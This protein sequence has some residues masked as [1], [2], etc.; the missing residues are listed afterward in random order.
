M[1]EK[2]T[3]TPPRFLKNGHAQTFFPEIFR[4]V[5]G[6]KYSRERIITM[7]NDFIDLDWSCIGSDDLVILCHGMEANSERMYMKGM[8]KIF[9]EN[10]WD[11]LAYNFRGCGGEINR[12]PRFYYSG[13]LDDFDLVISHALNKKNYK[14]VSLIGFSLGGSLVLNYVGIKGTKI[15]PEIKN[16]AALS[17]PCDYVAGSKLSKTNK[18]YVKI[19]VKKLLKKLEAKNGILPDNIQVKDYKFVKDFPGFDSLYTAP[20]HGF[21]S[22]QEYWEKCSCS[23]YISNITIPTLLINA[24]NDPLLCD[25]CFPIEEA[26]LSDK[27]FLE[28]PDGGGHLG[29]V[30]FGTKG[31]YWH[32]E[33]VLSFISENGI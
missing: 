31:K 2:S 15:I 23:Q 17:V 10:G 8:V 19:F 14:R 12:L 11:G 6:V 13:D 33:R 20:L 7:D 26:K 4:R 28:I 32:E 18:L 3:Y 5:K 16:A 1:I 22:A 27:F 30:T 24:K 29:F 21:E 9:N 25:E